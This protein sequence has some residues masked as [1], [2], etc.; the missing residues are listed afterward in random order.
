MYQL[1]SSHQLP[2]E[3]VLLLK[4]NQE[5]VDHHY[6]NREGNMPATT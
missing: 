5:T 1:G 4:S 2:V 3:A 6:N